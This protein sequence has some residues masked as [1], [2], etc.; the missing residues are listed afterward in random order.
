MRISS[1]SFSHGGAI[2]EEFAFAVMD[3]SSHVALGSNRN[4]HVEWTDIPEGTKSFVLI[5]YDSDVPSRA[6]DVNKE[7]REVPASLPRIVFFHW[8]LMDIPARTREISAG[9]HSR[10][11]TRRGKAG[12]AAPSGL[13][14]GINDF[15]KWFAA[16]AEMAGEYYGY[17]GPA[18]P[19]NDALLHHY[20]FTVYALDVT[21]LDVAGQL[22]GG[23]IL[24]AVARHV[25]GEASLTGTYSLNARVTSA[26]RIG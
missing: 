18:P 23:K 11:V 19:W 1:Q 2:P 25:L 24:A 10:G 4:P 5:C 20:T 26:T 3:S 22:T 15:T 16:D 13:R 12:P 21:H 9:A 6:D 7:D 17:D 8:L 14:H